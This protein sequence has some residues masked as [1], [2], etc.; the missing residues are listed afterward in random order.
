MKSL[1]SPAKDCPAAKE[2]SIILLTYYVLLILLLY[3]LLYF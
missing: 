2:C 3:S 1:N